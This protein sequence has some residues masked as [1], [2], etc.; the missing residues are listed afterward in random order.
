MSVKIRLQRYG[1]K[2]SAYYHI[3]VANSRSPRDG[4]FKEMIGTYDPHLQNDDPKRVVINKERATYWLGCGAQP[5]ER[6]AKFF[7]AV[8]IGTAAAS[9]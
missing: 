3:V 5:T 8:S 2:K 1:G 7:K 6:V 9:N 4:R